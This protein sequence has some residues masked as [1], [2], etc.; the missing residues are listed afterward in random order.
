MQTFDLFFVELSAEE[1]RALIW[2]AWM[3]PWQNWRPIVCRSASV[4]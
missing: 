1:M 4:I 2:M 3:R